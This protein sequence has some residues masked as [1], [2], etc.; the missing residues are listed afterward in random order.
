MAVLHRYAK[1]PLVSGRSAGDCLRPRAIRDPTVGRRG[2]THCKAAGRDY[3]GCH[4]FE[5]I[6]GPEVADFEF[7]QANNAE[8]R[9]LDVANSNH[10]T[11]AGAEQHFRGRAGQRQV[12]DL[13]CLLARYRR[14]VERAQIAIRFERLCC[15]NFVRHK[16]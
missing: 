15:I 3:R 11:N 14:L 16:L 1:G 4:D 7:A 12:E 6:L 2:M 9:R 5:V 8:R 13:V 10:A